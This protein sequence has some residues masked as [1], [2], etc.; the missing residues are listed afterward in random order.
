[1]IIFFQHFQELV[2]R[3]IYLSISYLFVI[4]IFVLYYENLLI[5]I[6]LPLFKLNMVDHL[7]FYYIILSCLYFFL[8]FLRF[9][10]KYFIVF[11]LFINSL[12]LPPDIFIQLI[13][14]F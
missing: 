11:T 4:I 10:R 7:I 2:Y 1:M 13:L 6:L 14:E 9:P 8:P 12:I 5:N 3:L